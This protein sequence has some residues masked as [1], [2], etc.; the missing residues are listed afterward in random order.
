[1]NIGTSNALCGLTLSQLIEDYKTEPESTWHGLRWHVRQ[2]HESLLRRLIADH[3][4]RD[5]SSIDTRDLK[6]WHRAW[7]EGGKIATGSSFIGKL[8]TIMTHGALLLPHGQPRMEC[9]RVKAL[10]KD[11]R[12]PQS[13]PREVWLTAEHVIAIRRKAHEW[14]SHSI[15]LAQAIQFEL[16]LRQKDV[17]GEYVPFAEPGES[18]VVWRGQKWLRGLRWSEIGEDMVLRHTTSK[19]L[20][21]LEVDLK[22]SPMVLE[23]LRYWQDF[24][25]GDAP[26]VINEGTGAPWL[27]S[28]FRRKWRQIANAAGIPKNIR[29]MDSRS[30][31]ITE[32]SDAGAEMEHIRQAATHSDIAMTGRYS[33][34]AAGKVAAV[35]RKRLEHRAALSEG[36]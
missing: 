6:A 25:H 33:R 5:L 27:A 15:A 2:N 20:K 26:I 10:L 24:R 19:R 18:N 17:I 11:L 32:A 21:K 30:G 22:L 1:M 13:P 34:N 16:I 29:S 7:T 12:F 9:I 14:G 31:G 28:E 35:Q 23:E 36:Q 4:D 3:G 8:R